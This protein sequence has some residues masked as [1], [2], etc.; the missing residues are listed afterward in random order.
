MNTES[1]FGQNDPQSSQ[2]MGEP[3]RP[4]N[5][6]PHSGARPPEPASTQAPPTPDSPERQGNDGTDDDGTGEQSSATLINRK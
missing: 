6:P 4:A 3:P 1:Q 5:Q 2:Q